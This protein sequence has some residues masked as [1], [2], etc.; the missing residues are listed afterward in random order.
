MNINT[1][2]ERADNARRKLSKGYRWQLYSVHA[3]KVI[4]KDQ[5]TTHFGSKKAINEAHG[6]WEQDVQYYVNKRTENLGLWVGGVLGQLI[7][8]PNESKKGEMF[9][10]ESRDAAFI[11]SMWAY[12]CGPVKE[13]EWIEQSM[14]LFSFWPWEIDRAGGI[15]EVVDASKLTLKEQG[16]IHA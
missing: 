11:F 9:I 14:P 10:W 2:V 12:V 6:K 7:E 15:P 13:T 1:I 4:S 8:E 5:F 16:L 3:I